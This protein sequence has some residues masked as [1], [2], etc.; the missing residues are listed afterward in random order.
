M[1]QKD[2]IGQLILQAREERKLSVPELADILK[3]PKDRIYKWEQGKGSPRF[4]DRQ[5]VQKCKTQSFK[6]GW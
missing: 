5:A 2:P 3:I 6:D 4:E 1:A